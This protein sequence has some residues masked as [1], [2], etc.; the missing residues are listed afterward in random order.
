[1]RSKP[2]SADNSAKPQQ[3]LLPVPS[4]LRWFFPTCLTRTARST[5]SMNFPKFDGKGLSTTAA[6]TIRGMIERT[7]FSV[8]TDETRYSLNGVFIEE[9][10]R[11]KVRMVATDGARRWCEQI[12]LL[13][14]TVQLFAASRLGNTPLWV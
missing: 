1:M 14:P 11:G 9:S 2:D 7:I 6:S 4:L 12:R 10:D 3:T 13:A 5:V 8:S